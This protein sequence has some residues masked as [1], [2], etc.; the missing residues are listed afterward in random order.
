[1]LYAEARSASAIQLEQSNGELEEAE[2]REPYAVT[3]SFKG[4][5]PLR[6]GQ[7]LRIG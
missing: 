7:L 6:T 2:M 4:G 3:R 1:M 5:Y